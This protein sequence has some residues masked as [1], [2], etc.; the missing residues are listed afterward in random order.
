MPARAWIVPLGLALSL[1]AGQAA[2]Q[3]ADLGRATCGQLIDL[4]RQDQGQVILWLHGYYAG[5]AQRALLDRDRVDAAVRELIATC[6]RDR[7]TLLIGPDVRALLL[8]DPAPRPPA[9]APSSETVE[10]PRPVR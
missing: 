9:P 4:P 8:G 6:G 2:A 7:S 3:T 5:A 1:A 10:T